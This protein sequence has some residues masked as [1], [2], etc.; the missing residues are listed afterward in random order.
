MKPG[1][2]A[3]T[4]IINREYP[5]GSVVQM[6]NDSKI[7]PYETTSFSVTTWTNDDGYVNHDYYYATALLQDISTANSAITYLTNFNPMNIGTGYKSDK[8]MAVETFAVD[9]Y[10]SSPFRCW[11]K[12]FETDSI[13]YY[14]RT[15]SSVFEDPNGY[16]Q[17]ET[18]YWNPPWHFDRI[19][20]YINKQSGAITYDAIA[21]EGG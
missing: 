16:P 2:P 5:S 7:D 21:R 8:M 14:D 17:Q 20:M 4:Y 19:N 10:A 1:G 6:I 13:Y 9:G 3:E 15:P 11:P 18:W 12:I